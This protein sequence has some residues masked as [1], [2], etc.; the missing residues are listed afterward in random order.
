MVLWE[1][2]VC[3]SETAYLKKARRIMK[4][5]ASEHDINLSVRV[6]DDSDALLTDIQDNK[7]W[8][9]IIF[10]DEEMYGE[11]KIEVV[12][13]INQMMSACKIV[14]LTR[15]FKYITDIYQTEHFYLIQ[16]D[17]L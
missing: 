6:Y 11:S 9:T 3:D 14:Y 1:V 8:P 7:I 4:A 17:E 10:I 16:K 12:K 2:A 5:Y 15:D 13:K